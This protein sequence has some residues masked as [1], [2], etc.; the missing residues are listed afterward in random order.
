MQGIP[1][2][3]P[4]QRD[5]LALLAKG[6]SNKQIGA[7]LGISDQ[8]ART[9]VG[10]VLAE[11]GVTNRTEA[12]AAYLAVFG[13]EGR[14]ARVLARP[15]I[16][17]LP[18]LVPTGE[19]RATG[20]A[21]GIARDLTSLFSRYSAFPVIANASTLDARQLGATSREIGERLGARFLVDG[22]LRESRRGFRLSVGIVD[23]ESGCS[24]WEK[25][26]TLLDEQLFEV[27]DGVCEE[28]VAAA[29][30]RLVELVSA[31][32]PSAPRPEDLE[33]WEIAH[34]AYTRQAA[35]SR[36]ANAAA[37]EG[38]EAAIA[39][40]PSLV[41][42]HFGLGLAAYDEVLN[43]WGPSG[44]ALSRLARSAERCSAIGPHMAEGCYLSAR[45][46]QASGDHARA[47]PP[48]LD[49]IDHNPSFAH[50]HA[51]LGQVYLLTGRP[52]EGR[53]RMKHACRLGPR[54][55]VAGLAVAHFACGE[56]REA[57]DAANLAIA[58]NPA[59][60]F[61][62]AIA[63]ASAHFLD[64]IEAA[65]AHADALLALQPAF[66]PTSFRRT[67]GAGTDAVSRLAEALEAVCARSRRRPQAA[68]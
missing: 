10:A 1:G 27:E 33:A 60:P 9:H 66:S 64:D 19:A 24:V 20:I 45:Y 62:R 11:L 37:R 41:L 58:A 68:S 52:E 38:F 59:Y 36:S 2:L 21:T 6:R 49:A 32:L 12:A 39:R 54:S 22:M 42:A 46:L 67:F 43:Q 63:A 5:V 50:A 13:G 44:A 14:V 23:A 15:A 29:Y 53:T 8:T 47:E 51:L 28:A 4:R 34:H 7:A 31:G 55:F 26:Q 17:V 57:L 16:A 25:E 65:D 35:R 61:G 3:T 40:D 18:L 48:L 30:A 56:N